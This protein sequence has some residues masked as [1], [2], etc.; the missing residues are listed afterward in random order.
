MNFEQIVAIICLVCPIM[1]PISMIIESYQEE[2]K[3]KE[4]L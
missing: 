2:K 4:G 3:R 1:V